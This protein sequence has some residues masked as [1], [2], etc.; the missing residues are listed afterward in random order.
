MIKGSS[1]NAVKVLQT[2]LT[3]MGYDPKAVDGKFGPNTEKAVIQFQEK[4]GLVKKDGKVGKNTWA[5]L[6]SL[7]NEKSSTTLDDLIGGSD[8]VV[9]V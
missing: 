5:K 1:G 2:I 4:N 9:E 8:K 7:Y 6:C 3:Q